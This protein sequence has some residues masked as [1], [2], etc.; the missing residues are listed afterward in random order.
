ME[1]VI[2]AQKEEILAVEKK[3]ADYYNQ[4]IGTK[5]NFQMLHNEQKLLSDELTQKQREIQALEK[6]KLN[7]ERELLQLRPLQAQLQNFS[8]SNRAQIESNVKSEFERQK[9]QK[10][11]LELQNDLQRTKV[12]NEQLVQKNFTLTE[13]N[14]VL[15]EQ[16]RT[17][18]KETFEI[19]TKIQRGLETDQENKNNGQAISVLRDKER[20]LQR[21]IESLQQKLVLK[22]SEVNRANGKTETLQSYNQTLEAEIKDLRS[23]VAELN[24]VV[25]TGQT[26]TIKNEHKKNQHE[27]EIYDLKQQLNVVREENK[28]AV[29][30]LAVS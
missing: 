27:L 2:K 1:R 26:E 18:E 28:K 9:L 30:D 22:D 14:V 8:E 4:L 6:E 5:E 10:S 23:K 15:V 19:Q 20:E 25:H 7:Q 24:G 17:F 21:E 11:V 3:A 12:D 29:A 13:Q 16:I